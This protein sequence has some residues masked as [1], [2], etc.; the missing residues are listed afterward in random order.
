MFILV[1]IAAGEVL[2]CHLSMCLCALI[3]LSDRVLRA[4]CAS[5]TADIFSQGLA[6]TPADQGVKLPA[7]LHPHVLISPINI[8]LIPASSEA[9]WEL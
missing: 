1:W 5:A 6:F 4:A 8:S 7:P 3:E 2:R 9:V